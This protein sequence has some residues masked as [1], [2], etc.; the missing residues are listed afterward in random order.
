[1]PHFR[2]MSHCL[3]AFVQL[4]CNQNFNGLSYLGD[5]LRDGLPNVPTKELSLAKTRAE[6]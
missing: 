5:F 3:G 1:M 6:Y 2:A 4:L